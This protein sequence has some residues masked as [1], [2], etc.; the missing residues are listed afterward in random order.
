M[1]AVCCKQSAH[2]PVLV[3]S[4]GGSSAATSTFC[5]RLYR[6]GAIDR[7]PWFAD[8]AAHADSGRLRPFRL[9]AV[10]DAECRAQLGA[11]AIAAAL[12][13]ALVLTGVASRGLGE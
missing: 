5:F 2:S 1:D 8:L 7:K 6:S 3:R 9:V 11:G 10:P 4:T 13:A 12:A